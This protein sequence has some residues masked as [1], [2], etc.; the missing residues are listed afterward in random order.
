MSVRDLPTAADH[1]VHT[2]Y[3]GSSKPFS[4]GLRP[5]DPADWIEV[6]GHYAPQTAEKRRLDRER[7]AD[8]FVEEPET[9]A[10]Q[11]EILN[12]VT[13]HLDAHEDRLFRPL[14][15][16]TAR[17][18]VRRY[19]DALGPTAAPL[20]IAAM[21]IQEDL[22]VMRR[23][24]R[25]WR[26]AAGSLCF[27]SSWVL[28]EKFGRPLDAIH[29][30]VPGF[31]PG[32]RMAELIARMF[33]NLKV[34]QPVLRWNWSVQAG[35]ALYHPLSNVQRDERADATTSRFPDADLASAFI[36][37]ERQ[38]LRRLPVSGD[39]L[40]TIRIHLDPLRA[41]R[42]H[43]DPRSVAEGLASQLG[44]LDDAQLDYKGLKADR[45]R[46]MRALQQWAQEPETRDSA[47]L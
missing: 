23:G 30:P 40:F 2:P 41:L 4:I 25:G 1:P 14:G 3:D 12:L 22:I 47:L 37:V 9:R 6:D 38:T 24:E 26:L 32:T 44:L 11:A 42:R 46:L 18:E 36:R 21:Q 10:A 8:V 35:D 33:D 31:G 34:D 5:L 17:R 20:R 19:A 7:L 43:P 28:A 45:D 27:P 15:L 39:I 16:A 29:E 13:N